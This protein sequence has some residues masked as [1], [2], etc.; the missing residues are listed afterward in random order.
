MCSRP[1]AP[2]R[3]CIIGQEFDDVPIFL[4]AARWPGEWPRVAN[5]LK[6]FMPVIDQVALD[7]DI[8]DDGQL[9]PKLG[10]EL[11]QKP[12]AD[13]GQRM[14]ELVTRLHDC[15]FCLPQKGTGLL[16]WIGITHER[17][18]RD[19]WPAALIARRALRSGSESST[20]CRR[21]NHMKMVF[22]PDVPPIAKAY[23]FVNHVFLADSVVREALQQ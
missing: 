18:H 20:F 22:E 3:V 7:L 10:I 9:A 17:R 12:S 16:A 21:L 1:G 4:A 8:L 14:I 5:T 15:G 23:L 6:R 11:Y 2:L 19:I 13:L